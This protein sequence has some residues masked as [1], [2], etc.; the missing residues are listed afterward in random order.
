MNQQV[1]SIFNRRERRD[2]TT[3]A[4]HGL[5]SLMPPHV[6]ING[7][8]F[9]LV[10]AAGVRFP[11]QTMH[12]DCVIIDINQNMS[13][14]Y[15]GDA[16]YDPNDDDRGPPICFSDNGIGPST[17]S[18]EPQSTTCS[19]CSHNAW[20]SAV[21]EKTGKN[22]KACSDRKKVA[23]VAIGDQAGLCYQMQIPPASLKA[24]LKYSGQLQA[25]E[26]PGAG[27]KADFDDV[28]TRV[29][30]VD[31]KNGELAFQAVCWINSVQLTQGGLAITTQQTAQGV[32]VA[33]SPDGGA[34]LASIVDGLLDRHTTDTIVNRH[35]QPWS[36]AQ[37]AL[38][39]GAPVQQIAAPQSSQS[40]PA[41]R[42]VFDQTRY[43]EQAQERAAPSAPR[44]PMDDLKWHGDVAQQPQPAPQGNG[45]HGGPRR[46]AG[47]PRKAAQQPVQAP[48]QPQQEVI[49]PGQPMQTA[50]QPMHQQPAQ[51]EPLTGPLMVGGPGGNHPLDAARTN[52]ASQSF[53]QPQPLA[54]EMQAALDVAMGLTTK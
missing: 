26:A 32:Q 39:Q 17:N 7:N 30:F 24:F 27:R 18:T 37:Q 42:P 10:D 22:R 4:A 6:S 35:D 29:T 38:P 12:L 31:G 40:V 46:G 21:N 44:S 36:G 53:A 8:R 2:L 52:P 15:W 33:A 49:P 41:D 47:R 45:A 34:A 11:L 50:P 14:V 9:A 23:L 20:G 3:S 25:M 54:D 28:V 43:A 51:P 19:T 16:P 48:Q 5:G 13:K 1:P